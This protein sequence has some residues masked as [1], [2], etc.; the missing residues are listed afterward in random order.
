MDNFD[1]R[2][3]L[4]EGKLTKQSL[5][6]EELIQQLIALSYNGELDADEINDINYQLKS[7]RRKM[8]ASKITPDQ[9]KA[10]AEK[11]AATKASNIKLQSAKEQIYKILG[12]ENDNPTIFALDLGMHRDKELQQRFNDELRKLGFTP[13]QLNEK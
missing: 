10:S 9:R 5:S 4:K 3:Y 12:V 1:L 8:F 7:A 2:K 13:P 11:G 6:K